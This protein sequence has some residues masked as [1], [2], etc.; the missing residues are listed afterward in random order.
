M[1]RI[2]EIIGTIV[3]IVFAGLMIIWGFSTEPAFMGYLIGAIVAIILIL[4][5]LMK[6][7]KKL[8]PLAIRS[9]KRLG[10]S[11]VV[12]LTYAL[13]VLGSL[14]YAPWEGWHQVPSYPGSYSKTWRKGLEAGSVFE[15]PRGIYGANP[16]AV[17]G[18]SQFP[19]RLEYY[20]LF[21]GWIAGGIAS[22]AIIFLWRRVS[23]PSPSVTPQTPSG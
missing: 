12:V 19:P 6:L 7:Q 5:A 13:F 16:S 8:G 10:V 11:G 17:S 2:K 20:R 15:A 4:W 21:L 9:T 23:A 22:F 1:E 3:L 14:F 18:Y